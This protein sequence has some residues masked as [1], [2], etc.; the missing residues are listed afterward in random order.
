VKLAAVL[1]GLSVWFHTENAQ[2]Q[3]QLLLPPDRSDAWDTATTILTLSSVGLGLVMPRVFYSDPEVTV[4]W[5]ARFHVS[6]LA[7]SMTLAAF[8][9]LNEHTLKDSFAADRPGCDDTNRELPGCEDFGMFSTHALLSFS[10]FGQGT[11]IFVVD[12]AKWSNGRFNVGAFAGH[13]AVPAVLAVITG[14]GRSAG[15]WE[16][17]GQVWA[18]AGVGFATGFALGA[19][20]A[21]LQRPECGYTGSLI[22]W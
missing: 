20:Y 18:S 17:S 3:T 14:I 1:V 19:L 11:G 5:K 2:A 21:T 13:V 22:C 15:N 8:A 12:T 7:P 10:A 9:L 16:S 6:V 4:G